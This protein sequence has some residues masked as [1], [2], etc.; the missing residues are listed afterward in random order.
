M[1]SVN[2]LARMATAVIL[3]RL[4]VSETPVLFRSLIRTHGLRAGLDQAAQVLGVRFAIL[5]DPCRRGHARHRARFVRAVALL[6][7][8]EAI[9]RK[10]VLD[11]GPAVGALSGRLGRAVVVASRYGK[12]TE[13]HKALTDAPLEGGPFAAWREQQLAALARWSHLRSKRLGRIS[14]T[15]STLTAANVRADA[16]FRRLEEAQA[17]GS[18]D[19]SVP[20]PALV[21]ARLD[22]TALNGAVARRAL[23]AESA[24]T[25]LEGMVRVAQTVQPTWPQA[26]PG[27]DGCGTVR[28][29]P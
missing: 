23:S 16:V 21:A 7:R 14:Q 11:A 13:L 27:P 5:I 4:G 12:A 18:L 10:T 29:K 19:G 28:Q 25:R 26:A 3:R 20:H 15:L 9:G 6:L 24:L 1:T 22:F 17:K 2:T 8:I